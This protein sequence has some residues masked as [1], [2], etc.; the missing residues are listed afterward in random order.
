MGV[1]RIYI[2]KKHTVLMCCVFSFFITTLSIQVSAATGIDT[3][4]TSK[5]ATQI[6][7]KLSTSPSLDNK[8]LSELVDQLFEMENIP[9]G[10]IDEVKV[11]IANMKKKNMSQLKTMTTSFPADDIYTSFEIHNLFPKSDMLKLKSDS[12]IH[13]TLQGMKEGDYFHPYDGVITSEFGWRDSAMHNGI[14]IDL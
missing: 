13:L 11:A 10:L 2:V 5:S 1:F 3:V 6:L 9:E 7:K 8:E 4:K 14:D 12:C